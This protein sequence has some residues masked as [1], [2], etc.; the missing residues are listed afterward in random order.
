MLF[1]QEDPAAKLARIAYARENTWVQRGEAAD[2]VIRKT[3]QRKGL[4]E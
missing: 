4:H 2:E 3:L 1:E